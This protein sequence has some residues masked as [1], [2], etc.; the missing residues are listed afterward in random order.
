[1]LKLARSTGLR[2]VTTLLGAL[3]H[4]RIRLVRP[5]THSAS[6]RSP[7]CRK[8]NQ[9]CHPT[10]PLFTFFQI[11][12]FK[13]KKIF[14]EGFTFSNLFTFIGFYYYRIFF[15]AAFYDC[16]RDYACASTAVE[17]FMAKFGYVSIEVSMKVGYMAVHAHQIYPVDTAPTALALV[18]PPC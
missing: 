12:Q 6:P 11:L 7:L 10:L 13:A 18:S 15:F 2:P 8:K 5:C 4:T 14:M 17:N 1:M 3:R 16:A 9:E